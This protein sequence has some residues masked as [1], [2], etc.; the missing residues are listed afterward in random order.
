[1]LLKV[2][3]NFSAVECVARCLDS[4]NI[5]RNPIFLSYPIKSHILGP[6]FSKILNSS[7]VIPLS[8]NKSLETSKMLIF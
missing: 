8:K 2:I 5:L 7:L 6:K 4:Y 3:Y 1:M